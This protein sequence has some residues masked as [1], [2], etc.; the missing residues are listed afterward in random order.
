VAVDAPI[1][2]AETGGSEAGPDTL[3]DIAPDLV[4][5]LMPDILT[6]R[7]DAGLDAGSCIQRFQANGYS[8]GMDASIAACSSCKDSGGNSLESTC[9]TM[10]DCLQPAWPCLTSGNCWRDCRNDAHADS[11]A[12]SCV[13]TLTSAACSAH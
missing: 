2:G 5:D 12:E 9:K 10:I 3:P 1:P 6:P 7:P 11:V 4:V 13:V 8:L